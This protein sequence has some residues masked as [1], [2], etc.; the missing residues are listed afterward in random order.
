MKE[1]EQRY[2]ELEHEFD[3]L[4][5]QLAQAKGAEAQLLLLKERYDELKR[6]KDESEQKE[7]LVVAKNDTLTQRLVRLHS[8]E[9]EMAQLQID[10]QEQQELSVKLKQQ[11]SS[12]RVANGDLQ[13]QLN[14]MKQANVALERKVLVQAATFREEQDAHCLA[15]SKEEG[16]YNSLMTLSRAQSGDIGEVPIVAKLHLELDE[17]KDENERLKSKVQQLLATRNSLHIFGAPLKC[18]GWPPSCKPPMRLWVV[19]FSWAPTTSLGVTRRVRKSYAF[20]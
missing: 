18:T 20:H 10:L 6:S 14:S 2:C 19:L 12:T 5:K 3:T 17:K 4:Q 9:T 13:H 7:L 8:L 1:A 16:R 11:S 15:I